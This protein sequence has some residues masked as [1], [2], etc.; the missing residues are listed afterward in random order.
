MTDNLISDIDGQQIWH[1]TIPVI[2]LVAAA[3]AQNATQ[4]VVSSLEQFGYTVHD[5]DRRV[6]ESEPVDA[7]HVGLPPVRSYQPRFGN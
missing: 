2:A 4:A 3:T 6:F 1:V 5:Q 7:D